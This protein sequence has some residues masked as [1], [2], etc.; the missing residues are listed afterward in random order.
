M[1]APYV[2]I[3]AKTR[4]TTGSYEKSQIQS[5]IE[6]YGAGQSNIRIASAGS[7]LS[8]SPADQSSKSVTSAGSIVTVTPGN[9][10]TVMIGST[11]STAEPSPVESKT[12][13]LLSANGPSTRASDHRW[14]SPQRLRTLLLILATN[15]VDSAGSI[16]LRSLRNPTASPTQ[17]G[18]AWTAVDCSIGIRVR[19]ACDFGA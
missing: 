9:V 7:G 16:Q 6:A 5:M 8:L 17:K 19:G 1:G 15:N 10:C 12:D 11:G 4:R 18:A 2:A 14:T 13:R 3:V